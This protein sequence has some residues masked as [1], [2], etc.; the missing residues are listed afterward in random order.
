M[1][2]ILDMNIYLATKD[3]FG[4]VD[5]SLVNTFDL[6]MSSYD[7][8]VWCSAGNISHDHLEPILRENNR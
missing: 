4:Q 7:K 8:G 3:I 2:F 5:M 6:E 1:S